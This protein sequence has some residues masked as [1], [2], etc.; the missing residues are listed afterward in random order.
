[1]KPS[2]TL[3]RIGFGAAA[4]GNLYTAVSPETAQAAVDAAWSGG[5]RYFDTAPHYGLGVSEQR[6]GGALARYPR[7]EYVLSSKVGR[8]LRP[9]STAGPDPGLRLRAIWSGSGT[10]AGTE[11][12]APSRRV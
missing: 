8:L 1:M 4:I 9:G 10:S 2:L 5:I 11:F 12:C 6:L 7:D 3:T